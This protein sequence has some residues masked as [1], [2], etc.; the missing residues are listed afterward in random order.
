V[1]AEYDASRGG[2]ERAAVNARDVVRHLSAGDVLEIGVGTGLV[3]EALRGQAPALRLAGVDV[4]AG[5]LD[6]ARDRL[7]GGLVRASALRLPFPDACL[8]GV[9]AVHVLHLV[10]DKALA[11]AEAARVLRPGGRVVAV[12]GRVDLPPDELTEAT[13]AVSDLMPRPDTPDGVRR[14]AGDRLR[15]VAQHPSESRQT[16]HAPAELAD[17]VERRVW[18][19]LWTLDDEQ[20]RSQ[21]EPMIAALRALPDQHRPRLQEGRMTVTVLERPT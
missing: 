3:A 11:L 20:W 18:S 19:W 15:V 17:L 6:R 2:A 12:H 7:P 21:V 16:R 5:M 8:D 13:R 9:V 1:A 14:A 10:P 4:A